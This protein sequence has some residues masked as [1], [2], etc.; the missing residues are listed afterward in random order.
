M[1]DTEKDLPTEESKKIESTVLKILSEKKTGRGTT[2][3]R[4]VKWGKWPA[5]V[6]KRDFWIDEEDDNT[7]KMGKAKG[8]KLDDIEVIVTN[9]E[10]I[11]KLLKG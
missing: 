5:S 6:E 7:E 2:R 10:E 9:V 3:L 4:V 1:D 8:L 11:R